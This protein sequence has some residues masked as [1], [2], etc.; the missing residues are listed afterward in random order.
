MDERRKRLYGIRFIDMDHEVELPWQGGI[1]VM[2][3][4]LGF[5]PVDYA[6]GPLQPFLA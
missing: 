2:A 3:D 6:N 5:R 1:E 4:T